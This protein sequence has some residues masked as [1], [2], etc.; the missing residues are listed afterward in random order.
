MRAH[1][2]GAGTDLHAG[3]RRVRADDGARTDHG[4]CAELHVRLDQRVLADLHVRVH[5]GAGRVDERDAG[6]QVALDDPAVHL[7]A[8]GGELHA[9]VDALDQPAVGRDQRADALAVAAGDAQHVGQVELALRVVGR[10]PRQAVAQHR[11]VERVHTGVDLG[12]QLFGGGGVLLLDDPL[13][14][15]VAGTHDPAVADRVLHHGRQHGHRVAR[16]SVLG[17]QGLEGLGVEQRHVAV[18]HDH[19]AAQVV[20]QLCQAARDGV[21][22]ALLLRLHR[23]GDLATER[24]GQAFEMLGDGFPAVADDDGQVIGICAGRRAHRVFDE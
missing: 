17:Q 23:D 6:T 22:G 16:R 1:D 20:R 12:D 13:H 14:G 8:D 3:Q 4:A 7:G 9:V 18:A 15:A 10:Q 11:R 5:P 24:R 2:G 19:G 21:P